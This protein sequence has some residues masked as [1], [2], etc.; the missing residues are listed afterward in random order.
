MAFSFNDRQPLKG[1]V[2]AQLLHTMT[3]LEDH[4]RFAL[5]YMALICRGGIHRLGNDVA[6]KEHICEECGAEYEAVATDMHARRQDTATCQY[7]TNA[8]PPAD[9]LGYVLQYLF[10][11]R[12]R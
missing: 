3:R 7:C 1:E 9:E 12:P 11:A 5:S 8:M 10:L 2:R 4:T 6:M